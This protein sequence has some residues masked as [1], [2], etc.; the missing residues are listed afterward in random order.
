MTSLT[1]LRVY[2]DYNIRYY[3]DDE[4]ININQQHFIFNGTLVEPEPRK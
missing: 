4:T 2:I 1:T 3:D